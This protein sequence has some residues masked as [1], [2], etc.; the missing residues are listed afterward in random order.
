MIDADYEMDPQVLES[1]DARERTTRA[2]GSLPAL[3]IWMDPDD[4]FGPDGIYDNADEEGTEWEREAQAD[5]IEPDGDGFSVGCGIRVQGGSSTGN[6]KV[7]K[8]SLRLLFKD[9]YGPG[10]LEF[11][12]FTDGEVDR[13]NTLV[14]DAHMNNTWLHPGTDQQERGQYVRDPFMADL[15]R[16]VGGHAPRTR[17]TNVF[18]NGA[19]WGVFDVHER[20]DD[21]WASE[22]FGGEDTDYDIIRHG[23]ENVVA[24]DADSWN[25]LLSA[26]R[27]GA[28][29]ADLAARVDEQ[30]LADY[31]LVNFVRGNTD[32]P[33]HNWY[34]SRARDDGPWRFHSWDA[35]HVLEAVDHDVTGQDDSYSPG[36]LFVALMAHPEFR[37]L[38][39]QRAELHLASDGALGPD[40]LATAYLAR[41]QQLDDAIVLES[42]RW[43]DYRRTVPYTREAEWLQHLAWIEDEVLPMRSET[44]WDQLQA[45]GYLD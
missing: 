2:L 23:S 32:W 27:T 5:W 19:Y 21:A 14:L 45:R 20:P 34:A 28:D 16:S 7:P 35:E 8:V 38:F 18:L 44:V 15:Q 1:D 4:L 31:M 3:A 6:W 40:A 37:A 41:I 12:V 25:A 11:P 33:H 42:A 10:Q 39:A 30:D 36:E 17:F 43:G 9:E 13:F 24:G 29:H 22:R 26:V